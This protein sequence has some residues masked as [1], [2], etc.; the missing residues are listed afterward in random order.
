MVLITPRTSIPNSS[1]HNVTN[2]V[3]ALAA[4]GVGD[5]DLAAAI[6]AWR[7]VFLPII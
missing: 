6:G 2:S 1:D 7:S 5:L 4:A 3:V